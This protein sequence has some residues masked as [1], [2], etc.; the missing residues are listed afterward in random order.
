MGSPARGAAAVFYLAST[1]LAVA[2]LFLLVELVKRTGVQAQ[3]QTPDVDA[4]PDEEDNL[5]D[6]QLPLIGVAFP[7][8]VAML[9]LAFITCALLV[10]GLPPLAG[11]L[12]KVALLSAAIGPNVAIAAGPARWSLV[13]LLLLSSAFATISLTRAGDRKSVV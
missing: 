6:A 11:F 8:S 7:I 9:G 5:D 13:V 3:A 10:A 4:A 2:M 12:A 1:T